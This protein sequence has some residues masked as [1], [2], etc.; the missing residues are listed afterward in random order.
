MIDCIK[1]KCQRCSCRSQ[2]IRRS[3]LL[4]EQ[5]H[6]QWSSLSESQTVVGVI[7]SDQLSICIGDWTLR[8]QGFLRDNEEQKLCD[9]W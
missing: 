1:Q 8:V 9:N 2:M 6:V 7:F 4:A 3:D 5:L